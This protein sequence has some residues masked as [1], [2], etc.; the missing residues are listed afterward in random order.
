MSNAG[1][2]KAIVT[3]AGGL[4]GQALIARLQQDGIP[5][6]AVDRRT[7]E[8]KLP[9]GATFYRADVADLGAWRAS[10]ASFWREP[11]TT[12]LFHL[13]GIAHA[14]YCRQDPLCAEAVNVAGALT[15]VEACRRRGVRRAVFPSTALVYGPD[16]RV[17][18]TETDPPA[19]TSFYAATKLAAEA[20]LQGYA[21]DFEMAVD[22]VRLGNVYGYGAAPDTVCSILLQ[23]AVQGERLAVKT[24]RPIRDFIYVK[25][26]ADGMVRLAVSQPSAP[27]SMETG[28]VIG[29]F[30][31]HNLSSGRP[32]SIGKLACVI[33]QAAGSAEEP[34]ETEPCGPSS[35][36]TLVLDIGKLTE[37]LGWRPSWSL[38]DGIVEVLA[39]M[40]QGEP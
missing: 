30:R 37:T 3:G 15:A 33:A 26:V 5:V 8:R 19:P 23:Q 18:A 27:S 11:E 16:A 17:P 9:A 38:E 20:L 1:F 39:R 24:L 10:P 35:N 36:S 28:G 14:G 4:L 25:D 13:A 12:V 6:L 34:L 2:S 22:V 40:R 21:S 32:T 31:L 29:R 7:P